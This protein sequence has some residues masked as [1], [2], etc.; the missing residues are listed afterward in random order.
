MGAPKHGKMRALGGL[1]APK[2]SKIRALG[3][4]VQNIVKYEAELRKP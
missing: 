3:R 4:L 1:G 2:P